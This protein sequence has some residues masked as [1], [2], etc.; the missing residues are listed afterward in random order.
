MRDA[1]YT[2]FREH[3]SPTLVNGDKRMDR[4][5]SCSDQALTLGAASTGR[6]KGSAD[7]QQSKGALLSPVTLMVKTDQVKGPYCSGQQHLSIVH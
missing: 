5:C 7:A 2:D 4:G 1:G 6:R 3:P